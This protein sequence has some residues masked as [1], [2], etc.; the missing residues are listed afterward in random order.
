MRRVKSTKVLGVFI[1]ER[2]SFKP[3]ID[4]V[5]K[6]L[7]SRIGLLSRISYYLPPKTLDVI[8]KTLIQTHIDYGISIYGFT[9]DT[10]I[11]R[12]QRFQNRAI[13]VITRSNREY[14]E[15]F[16][17]FNWKR[18]IDRRNHFCFIKIY[19]CLNGL[20]PNQCNKTFRY[21]T[22]NTKTRAVSH[23]EVTV[24][25]KRT[26]SFGKS[27]FYS[28]IMEYNKL[29]YDIRSEKNFKTFVKKIKNL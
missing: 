6:K 26:E 7:N 8:Y 4:I 13:R 3:H 21:K 2:L 24:P 5:C 10:H 23:M 22:S 19:K 11:K 25:I 28:G 16:K 12:I 17:E 29:N 27:I 15:L 20:A 9:F 1:D 14:S 18:F